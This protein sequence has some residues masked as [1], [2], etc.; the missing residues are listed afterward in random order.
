MAKP[1]DQS[2]G[3]ERI[4]QVRGCDDCTGLGHG[5]SIVSVSV[6]IVAR[7]GADLANV[8]IDSVSILHQQIDVRTVSGAD[9]G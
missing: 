5:K 9:R 1:R 7:L 4:I 3:S 2:E 6:V 8:S